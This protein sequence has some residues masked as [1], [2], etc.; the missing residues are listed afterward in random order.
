MVSMGPRGTF[1]LTVVA[2]LAGLAGL[3]GCGDDAAGPVTGDGLP[4]AQ[5]D[6]LSGVAQQVGAALDI[7]S[8]P[9]GSSF[10]P[11]RLPTA[12]LARAGVTLPDGTRVVRYERATRP[13]GGRFR[14]L[15]AADDHWQFCV[16]DD[17]GHWLA[18][19]DASGVQDFGTGG[20]TACSFT[21]RPR[22]P[23][24]P[25]VPARWSAAWSWRSSPTTGGSPGSTCAV[26]RTSTA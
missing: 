4:T 12:L 26:W 17:D 11:P 2:G 15:A 25:A 16:V 6:R 10:P 19:G 20:A 23:T 14:E 13:D 8:N 5:V 7:V 3:A 24:G 21:G 22:R 9:P 18:Y 1:G